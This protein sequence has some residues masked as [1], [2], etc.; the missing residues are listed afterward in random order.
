[1]AR[2]AARRI[3]LQ[4]IFSRMLKGGDAMDV[5]AAEPDVKNIE[6]DETYIADALA[7][8][9]ERGAAF[10]QTIRALSPKRA[11]ERIPVLNRAILHLALYELEAGNDATGVIINE[12]V[13]LAKRFG[14]ES[15]ARFIHAVLGKVA[16]AK[17]P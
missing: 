8:T 5:L 16:D 1:M 4:M 14:E 15:D 3:A 11:L 6:G 13:E 9:A 17:K 7:M 10:D 12:A 2:H